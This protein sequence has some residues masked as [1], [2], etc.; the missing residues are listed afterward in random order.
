MSLRLLLLGAFSAAM[1]TTAAV[2]ALAAPRGFTV[3]DMVKMERVAPVLSPDATRVVYTVRTT[4]M[5]K[6]RGNTQLWLLDLRAPKAAP[7]LLTPATP[8]PPIRNGRRMATRSTSCPAAPARRR[9]GAAADRR[10]SSKVT[11]LPLDVDTFRLSPQGD[12]LLFSMAVYRDCADLACSKKRLDEKARSR[13]AARCTTSCSCATGI[14]GPMAATMLYSAPID[15][16]G[17]VSAEPVSL[18]GKLDG[19]VPSKPFG[20]NDEYHFSPDGKT[21]AFSARIAG[22]RKRGRPT[23]MSTRCQ[24]PAASAAT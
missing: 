14:P 5:D 17:K 4:D 10:R 24:P 19:D 3:E 8:A 22:K 16:S 12:R 13:P 7:R 1:A 15:A 6:N 9:C 23:S 21:V 2:P 20:D 18:S 11:D